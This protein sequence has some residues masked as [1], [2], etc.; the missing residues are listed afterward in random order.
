MR[1]TESFNWR[2]NRI[3]LRPE[4]GNIWD[5]TRVWENI[6]ITIIRV[7]TRARVRVMKVVMERIGWNVEIFR[8]QN[9]SL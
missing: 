8:R 3:R 1:A 5:I 7:I 4:K 9:R 2:G 6:K